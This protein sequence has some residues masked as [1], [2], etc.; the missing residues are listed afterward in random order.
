MFPRGAYYAL[1]IVL[2]VIMTALAFGVALPFKM[3][4]AVTGSFGVIF[5]VAALLSAGYLWK[6][7]TTENSRTFYT[8]SE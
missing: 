4:E 7:D 3:N 8:K 5:G 6:T 2:L 1:I